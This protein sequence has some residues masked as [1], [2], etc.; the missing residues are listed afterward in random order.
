MKNLTSITKPSEAV[1]IR[2]DKTE[3]LHL[4]MDDYGEEIKRLVYAYTKNW[5]HSEDL[6]QDIFLCVY[7]NLDTFQQQSSIKTWI[8]RIAINKCKDFLR[9]WHYKKTIISDIILPSEKENSP[10][11]VYLHSERKEAVSQ[12][13]LQLPVK[14]REVI[15]LYYFRDLTLEEMTELLGANVNTLKSRLQRAKKRLAFKLQ[16][17]GEM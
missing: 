12:L 13:I 4:L 16:Y 7:K 5:T 9:S 10:E 2:T 1:P 15:V 6:T 3:L 8:Y 14:Y 17:K 11:T